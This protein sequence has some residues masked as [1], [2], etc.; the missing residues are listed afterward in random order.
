MNTE[1]RNLRH[2]RLEQCA[3]VDQ[4][5][6]AV[7]VACANSQASGNSGSLSWKHPYRRNIC[8]IRLDKKWFCLPTVLVAAAA[9][10]SA[11]SRSEATRYGDRQPGCSVDQEN[12]VASV[13]VDGET[14]TV[15]TKD[16]Q[17]YSTTKD[18][19]ALSTSS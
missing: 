18:A 6:G 15:E 17:T 5:T 10:F 7:L 13:D 19:N 12:K 8:G 14:V 3:Q 16:G 1:I 2:L 4:T 11:C 9:L